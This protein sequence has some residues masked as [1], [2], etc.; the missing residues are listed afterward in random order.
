MTAGLCEIASECVCAPETVPVPVPTPAPAPA[1]NSGNQQYTELYLDSGKR[2]GN[3][4]H[5][6][7]SSNPS[8]HSPPKTQKAQGHLSEEE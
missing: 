8:M 5:Q 3:S 1:G 2:S 4:G 6:R 7:S